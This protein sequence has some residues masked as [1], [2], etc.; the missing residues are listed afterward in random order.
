MSDRPTA[1]DFSHALEMKLA[2]LNVLATRTFEIAELA[3]VKRLQ[4]MKASYALATARN[5]RD[6]ADR[7]EKAAKA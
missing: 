6:T 4:G 2:D 3:G 5:L 7:L 1:E